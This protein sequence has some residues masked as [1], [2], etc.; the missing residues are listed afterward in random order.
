MGCRD[1]LGAFDSQSN[2]NAQGVVCEFVQLH[3]RINS[4]CNAHIKGVDNTYL[5]CGIRSV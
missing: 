4:I 2:E 3:T 1:T 5:K